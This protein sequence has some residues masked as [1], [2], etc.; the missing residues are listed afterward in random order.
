MLIYDVLII[1]GGPGGL[2]GSVM[3]SLKNMT[4]CI[5]EIM[6]SLGGQ[7]NLFYPV[8]DIYDFPGVKSITGADVISGLIDQM[9]SFDNFKPKIYLES[10]VFDVVKE[11]V[12]FKSFL[13]NGSV[14]SS[15][16]IIIASGN[17]SFLMNKLK[18]NDEEV[19]HKNIGYSYESNDV[20]IDRDV[21][22]LGGGDSALDWS[23]H[24]SK[25]KIAKKVTIIHRNNLLRA[26][27]LKVEEAKKN[28]VIILLNCEVIN[29]SENKIIIS[30][31]EDGVKS[32]INFNK[33]LVQYG[34]L[35][36]KNKVVTLFPEVEMNGNKI[37][38]NDKFQ[39]TQK[40]VYAIGQTSTYSTKPNLIV[41]SFSEIAKAIYSISEELKMDKKNERE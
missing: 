19:V 37:I 40:M 17:S 31:N 16:S 15:K 12:I 14:I 39:T 33:I 23:I 25:N 3:A 38:V 22:I 32:E 8:K 26:R 4:S 27:E 13:S 34:F 30:N 9:N 35:P 41:V 28:N 10:F 29:L 6:P 18:I 24:L 21:V 36:S 2:Y 1:G 5:V 11:G 7:P 20:Y